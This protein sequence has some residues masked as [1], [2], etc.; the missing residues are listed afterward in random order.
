[1]GQHGHG[2]HQACA[3]VY[4]STNEPTSLNQAKHAAETALKCP[5][6]AELRVRK[7]AVVGEMRRRPCRCSAR[8]LASRRAYE[9]H[10]PTHIELPVAGRAPV[11]ASEI[12]RDDAPS[13]G[14]AFG[15]DEYVVHSND[16]I[17]AAATVLATGFASAEARSLIADTIDADWEAVLA[18]YREA[19][20]RHAD[21]R[22]TAE[23]I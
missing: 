19:L 2:R 3:H 17:A 5:S 4:A 6:T 21:G 23:D 22:A 14:A 1:T 18:R 11:V 8:R 16:A 20:V 15:E 12:D 10:R 13:D 7:S 9:G